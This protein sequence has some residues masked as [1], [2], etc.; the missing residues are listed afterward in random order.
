MGNEAIIDQNDHS[1]DKERAV[2]E[3]YAQHNCPYLVV[4]NEKVQTA[5]V[6]LCG[7]YC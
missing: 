6:R 5:I 1:Y 7:A 4:E 3:Q 2:L